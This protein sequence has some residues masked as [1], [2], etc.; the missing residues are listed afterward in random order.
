[1]LAIDFCESGLALVEGTGAV[2]ARGQLV[3]RFEGDSR[4]F[5]G[6]FIGT[7]NAFFLAEFFDSGLEARVQERSVRLWCRRVATELS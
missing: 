7:L 6:C 2:D 5:F 3:A 4:L 1:M